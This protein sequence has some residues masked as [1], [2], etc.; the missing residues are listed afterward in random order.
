MKLNIN[1]VA[2][3]FLYN[4][5]GS[6][7]NSI[8]ACYPH[9]AFIG[10]IASMLISHFVIIHRN[11]PFDLFILFLFMCW[12][13]KLYFPCLKYNSR[14]K[15]LPLSGMFN[16]FE[17]LELTAKVY[18]TIVP[19]DTSMYFYILRCILHYNFTCLSACL[20]HYD[21]TYLGDCRLIEIFCVD[22]DIH[23]RIAYH[24]E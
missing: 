17:Y 5:V 4:I 19:Y 1:S 8:F 18:R 6:F 2:F 9:P 12:L 3:K 16:F 10:K 7:D 11:S 14:K 20:S 22:C 13:P 24:N 15:N 21:F 23:S